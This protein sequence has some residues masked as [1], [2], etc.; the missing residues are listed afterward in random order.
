VIRTHLLDVTRAGHDGN[1][2]TGREV[3]D[4]YD[5]SVR[6]GHKFGRQPTND[7]IGSELAMTLRFSNVANLEHLAAAVAP[8]EDSSHRYPLLE[9]TLADIQ[10]Q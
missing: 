1:S 7:E 8:H 10:Q 5:A 2:H 4:F 3:S 6:L 9:E